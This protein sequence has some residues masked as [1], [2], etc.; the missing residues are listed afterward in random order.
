MGLFAFRS[1]LAGC[2]IPGF[3]A[4][5]W[6]FS[7]INML[8]AGLTRDLWEIVGML[9]GSMLSPCDA[10]CNW[11]SVDEVLR[12]EELLVL[13]CRS[14]H[15]ISWPW[16]SNL[17]M[18]NMGFESAYGFIMT[19]KLP[20][21]PWENDSTLLM[22]C[23]DEGI[24]HVMSNYRRAFVQYMKYILKEEGMPF[25]AAN[26]THGAHGQRRLM[27]PVPTGSKQTRTAQRAWRALKLLLRQQN[28][29]C[30]GP[31]D[32]C[33]EDCNNVTEHNG[34]RYH[35]EYIYIYMCIYT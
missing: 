7:V 31:C 28:S 4:F 19:G 17:N 25:S 15:S 5:G 27:M 33:M 12:R 2:L 18:F 8:M 24:F 35:W 34:T 14:A 6:F 11:P 30:Q 23:F 3:R 26:H 13:L 16:Y 21:F 32:P 9:S 20:V 10:G 22:W 29:C 1:T